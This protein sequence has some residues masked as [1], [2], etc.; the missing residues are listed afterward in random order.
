MT[1]Q[2]VLKVML[3]AMLIPIASLLAL[4]LSSNC[5]AVIQARMPVQNNG[6]LA[7]MEL[8]NV[9]IEAQSIGSLFSELALSF[10]IPIGLEIAL[11]R[12]PA[13]LL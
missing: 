12:R 3:K 9:Q 6:E 13:R 11:Q 10:N 8:E 4:L 2:E 7:D 5:F 1:D